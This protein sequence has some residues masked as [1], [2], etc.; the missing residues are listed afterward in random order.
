MMLR[1][2][3]YLAKLLV[4]YRID[5]LHGKRR[6]SLQGIIRANTPHACI[7]S[8]FQNIHL[9]RMPIFLGEPLLWYISIA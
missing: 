1:E 7:L 8:E 2:Y 9:Q 3:V 5:E 4:C 6:H